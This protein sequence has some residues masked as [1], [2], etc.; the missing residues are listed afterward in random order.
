MD[1]ELKKLSRV[2]SR[3]VAAFSDCDISTSWEV[4]AEEIKYLNRSNIRI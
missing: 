4:L 3:V 1:Y 2:A